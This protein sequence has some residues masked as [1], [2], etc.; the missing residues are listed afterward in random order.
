MRPIQRMIAALLGASCPVLSMTGT[1]AAAQD[2]STIDARIFTSTDLTGDGTISRRESVIYTD[3]VFV[4]M[5]A[6]SDGELTME[7]YAGWDPGYFLLAQEQG[8]ESQFD[9]AKE[10]NFQSLD[11]NGDGAL[12]FEEYSVAMLYD[13]YKADVNQDRGPSQQ[14]FVEEFRVL[15]EVR[16]ALQ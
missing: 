7:E 2:V 9:A 12:E 15:N 5:D 10:R 8:R 13:F 16:S 14:E 6:N 11:L 1:P 4:S 3:L